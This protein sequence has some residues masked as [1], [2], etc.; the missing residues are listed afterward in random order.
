MPV[1]R[2]EESGAVILSGINRKA[3]IVRD[4]HL[5][6]G[7]YRMT[8]REVK[9]F[10]WLVSQVGSSD[11]EFQKYR[12]QI[13]TLQELLGL[14]G[15]AIYSEVAD[16][17]RSLI[18]RVAEIYDATDDRLKQRALV[19][20]ADHVL[21][22]GYVELQLHPDLKRYVLELKRNFTSIELEVAMRLPT[23]YAIRMY[24][25]VKSYRYRGPTFEL[26]VMGLRK[27]LGI[28]ESQYK[29]FKDFVKRV[30]RPACA[31]I[32]KRTNIAVQFETRLVGRK[33]S[34]I[35][36]T[37][38]GGKGSDVAYIPGTHA[39]AW[40][41]ALEG[42]KMPRKEARKVIESYGQSDPERITWHLEE[43]KRLVAK[44]AVKKSPLAWLRAGLK[45]DYRR[46]GSLFGGT[47]DALAPR[48]KMERPAPRV[49]TGDGLTPVSSKLTE[50]IR[51]FRERRQSA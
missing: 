45:H 33:T 14:E 27:M 19:I 12:V 22:K 13:S 43:I 44:D 9:L 37:V 8:A 17:T 48:S 10:L 50:R 18:G 30:L 23:F 6:H 40:L 7:H 1:S 21:G 5:I 29:V 46:Q 47:G 4:N 49:N 28:E 34:Q 36:F 42:Y 3:L 41:S 32:T 11:A 15:N 31:E 26:D 20:G 16:V 38:T 2:D 39:D 24:E 51:A 35:V 25:I